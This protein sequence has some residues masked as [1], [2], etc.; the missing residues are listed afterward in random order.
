MEVESWEIGRLKPY[1]NNPRVNDAAVSAVAESI[2][3]FGFRQ[4]IVVDEPGVIL[5]GH[6]R[7]KAALA[8]GLT[9]VPV[10]VARGLTDAQAR[11]YRLADN[12]TRDRSSWDWDLLMQEIAGIVAVEIDPA[13]LG[14]DDETLRN[15]LAVKEA[16]P[17][18]EW[19]MR[20]AEP[21][22]KCPK[23]GYEWK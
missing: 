5:A 8:L 20:E 19:P 9:K 15:L 18:C 16:V 23:C 21:K 6:T 7:W 12:A 2:R 4:P 3:Q 17:P 1:E 10:H 22:N 11:A 13:I 14:F